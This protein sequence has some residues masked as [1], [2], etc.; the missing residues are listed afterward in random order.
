MD[1]MKSIEVESAASAEAAG[2]RYVSGDGPGISR[3]RAGKGFTYIGADS[4]PVRREATLER[5][6]ALVLPPA[7]QNVWICPIANGH[8]QAVGR[9]ARGRKQYSYHAHYREIRDETKFGRMLAFEAALPKIRQRV[10][11]DLALPGL[12]QR[13]VIAAI[14]GLLDETCIRVG[15]EEYA[16]ANKSYGLTTLKDR[17]V[18][19]HGDALHLQFRGKSNQDH[20]ITLKDRRLA[21]IV[22]ECQDLPGQELF[23]YRLENGEYGKVDSAD[24][25][26]YLRE[27]QNR[28]S[29]RK[30]SGPG[31]GV[32]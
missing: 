16:K 31:T 15:N 22:K 23:Q 24:V 30:I 32:V 1:G 18:R 26:D 27:S 6:Q 5:I 7:W 4:K 2:L 3:R 12:P 8:I 11:K 19:F 13:K 14:V 10:E 20:D 17:H 25:N 29:P 9:D 21:K 28:I